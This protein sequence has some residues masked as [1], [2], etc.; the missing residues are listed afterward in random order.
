MP[1]L[2]TVDLPNAFKCLK[3]RRVYSSRFVLSSCVDAGRFESLLEEMDAAFPVCYIHA[4]SIRKGTVLL[5]SPIPH[6][7]TIPLHVSLPKP[8]LTIPHQY[9][10]SSSLFHLWKG[11]PTQSITHFKVVG[12]K[13]EAYLH[14]LE[15]ENMDAAYSPLHTA[16][17]R[18]TALDKLGLKR[19]C[20]RRMVL[21][22]VDLIE[23]LLKYSSAP[24]PLPSSVDANCEK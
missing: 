12:N 9:D 3:D 8:I 17:L 6:T 20:C 18:R 2:S 1:A 19:Y 7:P 21:T 22:H 4:F 15:D 11:M 16:D 5:E 13:W 14:Y 23:T 24:F 10:H